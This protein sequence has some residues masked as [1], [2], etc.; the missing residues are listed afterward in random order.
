MKKFP[1]IPSKFLRARLPFTATTLQVFLIYHF[2][3]PQWFIAVYITLAL[4]VWAVLIFRRFSEYDLNLIMP[5]KIDSPPAAT[6]T[7]NKDTDNQD[8]KPQKHE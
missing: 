8:I 6:A 4:I 1:V 2:N 5:N 3:A 7:Q